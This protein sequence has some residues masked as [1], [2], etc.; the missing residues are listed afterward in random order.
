MNEHFT[1]DRRLL[2]QKS[3][4]KHGYKNFT[5]YII[6]LHKNPSDDFLHDRELHYYSTLSCKYNLSEPGGFSSTPTNPKSVYVYDRNYQP[7]G[8]FKSLN[9]ASKFLGIHTETLRGRIFSGHLIDNKYYVSYH[10]I[11]QIGKGHKGKGFA[12]KLVTLDGRIIKRFISVKSAC[13]WLGIDEH[14]GLKYLK[15]QLPIRELVFIRFDVDDT[16]Q[17]TKLSMKEENDYL[18]RFRS[19]K[20]YNWSSTH[21][22]D[23]NLERRI[24]ITVINAEG[25][26]QESFLSI[27]EASKKLGLSKSYVGK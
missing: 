6:E 16:I 2:I 24:G 25:K 1:K 15:L 19:S 4:R 10:M 17:E 21:L 23:F 5:I 7:I 9:K 14:T 22:A 13:S 8:I 26:V 18:I 12:V 11:P 27:S 3:I 20:K